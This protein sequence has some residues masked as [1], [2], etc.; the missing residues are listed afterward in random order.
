MMMDTNFSTL[1]LEPQELVS[2]ILDFD[3]KLLYLKQKNSC[4]NYDL[5][6]SNMI[7]KIN[8]E[9]ENDAVNNLIEKL[10]NISELFDLFPYV[11]YLNRTMELDGHEVNEFK[12]SSPLG[13]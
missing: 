12:Y 8:E 4:K 9:G 2:Y 5:I 11:M 6:V 10:P 13:S 1:S 7:P 3:D